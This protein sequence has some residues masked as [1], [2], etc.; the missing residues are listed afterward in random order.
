MNPVRS[1]LL[2]AIVVLFGCEDRPV[3]H[4]AIIGKWRSNAPL[5]L[6]SV[7]RVEGI[8]PQTR[9][10]LH[11]DFFG[12]MEVEIKT[13]ES[14]TTHEKDN[15]DSGFGPYEVLE[16]S[17]GFVRIKSWNSFFQDYDIRTLY[18]EGECYYEIF[19]EFEFRQYFC[20]TES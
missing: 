19:R 5:T 16:V 4:E 13:N 20:R 14:R 12:H 18:L 10:F 9:A 15:Y 3:A 8:T 1:A 17:D 6:E 2:C 7:D 11:D